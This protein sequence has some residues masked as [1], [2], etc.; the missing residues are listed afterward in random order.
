MS[1]GMRRGPSAKVTTNF[2]TMLPPTSP[3]SITN[4]ATYTITLKVDPKTTLNNTEFTFGH[5]PETTS[6]TLRR[7]I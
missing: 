4:T 7:H 3:T 1:E 6:A 2:P 5:T